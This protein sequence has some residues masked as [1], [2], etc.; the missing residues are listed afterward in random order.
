MISIDYTKRRAMNLR[1]EERALVESCKAIRTQAEWAHPVDLE[2][3]ESLYSE[4]HRK[5]IKANW[6]DRW[7]DR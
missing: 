2:S 7:G 4:L 3:Q 6:G 5:H 1:L